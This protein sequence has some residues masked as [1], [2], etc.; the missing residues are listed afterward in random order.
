MLHARGAQWLGG[1]RSREVGRCPASVAQRFQS[2]AAE[3]TLEENIAETA[4]KDD[5]AFIVCGP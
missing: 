1:E 3:N 5:I 4:E 2:L